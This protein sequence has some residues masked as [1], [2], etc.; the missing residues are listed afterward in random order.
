M[1]HLTLVITGA[2]RAQGDVAAAVEVAEGWALVHSLPGI[3]VLQKAAVHV[4]LPEGTL[5]AL[6]R[7]TL[8]T[9]ATLPNRLSMTPPLRFFRETCSSARAR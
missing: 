8:H 5:L 6:P 7:C 1:L 2:A 3:G 4:V 9:G